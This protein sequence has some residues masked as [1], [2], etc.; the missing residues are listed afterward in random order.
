[1]LT[2]F[3]YYLSHY[4]SFNVTYKNFVFE[5]INPTFTYFAFFGSEATA[6]DTINLIDLRLNN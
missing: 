2:T 1:V 6:L 3:S 5:N 4:R